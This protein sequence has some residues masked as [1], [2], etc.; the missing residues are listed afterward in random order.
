MAVMHVAGNLSYMAKLPRSSDAMFVTV[1]AI[2]V[3][4]AGHG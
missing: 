2:K 4:Y 3:P 1:M